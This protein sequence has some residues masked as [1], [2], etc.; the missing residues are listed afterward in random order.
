MPA[1]G[2]PDGKPR[3]ADLLEE[4]VA[5]RCAWLIR[6]RWIAAAGVFAATAFASLG[7]GLDLPVFE[8]CAAGAAMLG[9]NAGFRHALARMRV[10]S[11]GPRTFSRFARVQF[12]TD[13]SILIL[14][15]HL[16]GGLSSPLLS[17][18]VFHAI[19]AAILLP[20]RG[21]YLHATAGV[22]MVVGLA[23]LESSEVLAHRPVAS[24]WAIPPDRPVPVVTALLSFA[25]VVIGSNHLA[26]S[27]ARRLWARTRE[28][29]ALKER[30]EL[31]ADRL[32]TLHDV[33]RA[34]NSTLN[35][36]EV[37]GHIVEATARTMRGKA[38]S[39]RLL[40]DGRTVLRVAAAHGLS[41]EYLAKGDVEVGRSPIDQAALEGWAVQ[42]PDVQSATALQFP[43]AAVREGIGSMICAP[44][45][46]R[47]QA[48][49]VL[50]LYSAEPRRFGPDEETFLM[51]IAS[52]GAVAIENA[53]AY[54]RLEELEAAKSRFVFQVAHELK[55]PVAAVR[56]MLALLDSGLAGASE[57]R[58]KEL[59][60][61]CIVRSADLQATIDDLLALGSLR[62]RLPEARPGPAAVAD[63]LG[64]VAER[65][66]PAVEEKRIDL[67]VECEAGDG[68]PVVRADPD[69]LR[70]LIG[71]L[72]ENAVKYTPPGGKVRLAAERCGDRVVLRC[73]DT[74]IGIPAEA[75]P[76]L[77]E[78]FYR[79]PN[80]KAS[81]PG[82]GL[83]LS[84]VKRIVDLYH[85]EIRVESTVGQGTTFT[86]SLP[87]A[88]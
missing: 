71:N 23:V 45:M 70:K 12:V 79:A 66:A 49:G 20:P 74:G 86:V 65:V 51:A 4:E 75:I 77:F 36:D 10:S 80:A 19:I 7:L 85:G 8:L 30:F 11:V 5:S 87:A 88:G 22:L 48:I 52:Q 29:I 27:I 46:V 55:S 44:L 28:S 14:L 59:L 16:T 25:V 21:S 60:G 9:I 84:L 53:S 62:R 68:G 54:R 81:Y 32:R 67:R 39:I 58:R 6:Y 40:D 17:F 57:E 47:G 35:L 18:F 63:V 61:R 1:P 41:P 50:R 73:T 34:V 78:E 76:R 72:L 38:A 82:T 2:H 26:G 43:D 33:A 83:G 42:V 56:Q 24:L 15:V 31:D 69:D 37:L 13:W 64:P 3:P